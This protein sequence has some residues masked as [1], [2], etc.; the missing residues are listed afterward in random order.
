MFGVCKAEKGV[1]LK[2]Q[3]GLKRSDMECWGHG[4]MLL[5]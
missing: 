4:S 3:S 5:S 1:M 2:R